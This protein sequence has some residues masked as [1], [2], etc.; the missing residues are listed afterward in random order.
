MAVDLEMCKERD[1]NKSKSVLLLGSIRI[2]IA[3]GK[4]LDRK[5]PSSMAV[6]LRLATRVSESAE[7]PEFD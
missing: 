7:L 6:G 2:A 1:Q 5:T 4:K 3:M